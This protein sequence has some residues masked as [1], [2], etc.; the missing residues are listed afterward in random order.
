MTV[1]DTIYWLYNRLRVTRCPRLSWAG[2]VESERGSNSVCG[3]ART[4]IG[5]R[6][7]V[8]CFWSLVTNKIVLHWETNYIT[9]RYAESWVISISKFYNDG[10][11]IIHRDGTVASI[12]FEHTIRDS[13]VVRF[14]FSVI[15]NP[16]F[17]LT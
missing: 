6:H 14:F 5:W 2:I 12:I 10:I 1:Y 9:W 13:Q 16:P 8:C 11:L 3:H 15:S 4:Q 7:D 17:E